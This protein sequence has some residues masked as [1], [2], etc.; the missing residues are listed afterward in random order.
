MKT[1]KLNKSMKQA[2]K[3]E[4]SPLLIGLRNELKKLGVT[5]QESNKTSE[6]TMHEVNLDITEHGI[7]VAVLRGEKGEKGDIAEIDY[8]KVVDGLK[9]HIP[10]PIKGER[11]LRGLRGV[12]GLRGIQE[13]GR[14]H[15]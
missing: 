6:K 1:N 3:A 15:V 8:S 7:G 11:G 4:I 9:K 12:R 14:A 5:V 2:L 13:I 10:K